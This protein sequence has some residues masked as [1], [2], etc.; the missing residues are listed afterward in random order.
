MSGLNSYD[1]PE[2]GLVRNIYVINSSLYCFE[3]QQHS[4]ICF[5][6]DYM[7]YKIEIPTMAQATELISANNLVDFTPYYSFTHK[8]MTYVTMKYYLGDV[9]GLHRASPAAM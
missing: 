2:F 6:K 7:A 8:D 5:D 1:L 3:F 4:T 9:I